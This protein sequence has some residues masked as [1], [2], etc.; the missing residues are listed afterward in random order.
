L[1]N[2][3][4]FSCIPAGEQT[5]GLGFLVKLPMDTQFP[6]VHSAGAITATQ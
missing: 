4:I 5:G 1:I 6:R 3:A 2:I